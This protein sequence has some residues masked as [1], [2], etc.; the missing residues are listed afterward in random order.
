MTNEELL[1]TFAKIEFHV[2][3]LSCPEGDDA[4]YIVAAFGS[5][6]ILSGLANLLTFD[7]FHEFEKLDNAGNV[8]LGDNGCPFW[9]V[10]AVIGGLVETFQHAID[11]GLVAEEALRAQV[12]V[13]PEGV[14]R[15]VFN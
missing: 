3:S 13:W 15:S 4:Y 6:E 9:T 12:K 2:G 10:K 1:S 5:P 11:E 8:Q 7:E 14:S